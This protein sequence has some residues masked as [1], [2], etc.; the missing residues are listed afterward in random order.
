MSD[1]WT[2]LPAEFLAGVDP[3]HPESSDTATH[4]TRMRSI[5]HGEAFLAWSRY[6]SIA[7]V[8]DQLVL[9]STGGFFI[10]R[11]TEM[12]TRVCR[13]DAI[14]RY[15]ADQWV[16][17]ALALRERLPKVLTTLRDGIVSRALIQTVL[18]RTDLITDDTIM[19]DLDTEI[20]HI[21]RSRKGAWSKPKLRD[22][23]DRL[24]FRH[25]PDAVRERRREAVDKRG[26]YTENF[27]DGT[28]EITG[29]MVAENVRIAAKA[30]KALADTVCAHDGR[31]RNQRNS[32]AMFALLTGTAYECQCGREECAADIPDPDE[33]VRSVSTEVVIHVVTDA[34]TLAGAPGIGWVDGH[35]VVSDDHV[36]DLAQRPDATIKPVTPVRTPPA[37]VVAE[38]AASK[39]V[40]IVYPGAQ[41]ADPYRPT[42]ACADFVRVRDGYCTEPGCPSSSFDSDLDHVTEY[43]RTSPTQGG[44]TSSENLNAK[45]RFGHLHKTFG[46]WIDTQCRDDDGHL[47]TEYRTPEGFTIPGDAE[48]LEDFFPNL[49]RIRYEQPPQAPPTPRV[50]TGDD[51]PSTDNRLARKH[52]RRRAERARNKKQRLTDQADPPPF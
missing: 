2:D 16:G 37:R 14:T 28:G 17:E 21:L 50:I 20:E 3:A 52:A 43:D 49:R 27:V 26:M 31:N 8:Y 5:R 4:M 36:R 23:V 33:V 48:T 12:V 47:V 13:E 24:V 7:T 30:V 45:C 11:Y 15:Q 18:S 39:D 44:A 32:D 38:D 19:A 35:G 6:Q 34:A 51:A 10:D 46:D 42:A 41:P 40:V 22:M 1:K 9:N 25:D 29:V